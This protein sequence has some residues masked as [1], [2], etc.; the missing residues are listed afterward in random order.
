VALHGRLI[1]SF[2]ILRGLPPGNHGAL[3]PPPNCSLVQTCSAITSPHAPVR[4]VFVFAFEGIARSSD[5]FMRGCEYIQ[6]FGSRTL[7]LRR[8]AFLIEEENM[9]TLLFGDNR[10]V[11]TFG[12][13]CGSRFPFSYSLAISSKAIFVNSRGWMYLGLSSLSQL[14]CWLQDLRRL[15]SIQHP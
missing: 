8:S 4:W 5:P 3:G 12:I 11:I 10:A 15:S 13:E 14:F 2:F 6:S 9:I 7:S 1:L